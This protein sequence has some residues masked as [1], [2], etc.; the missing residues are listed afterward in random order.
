MWSS[1]DPNDRM[2]MW[3]DDL[4]PFDEPEYKFDR[5]HFA[6]YQRAIAVHTHLPALQ[7]GS[8]RPVLAD[9]SR[10]VYAF[11]R[12]DDRQTVYV[13]VNRN[14]KAGEVEIPIA[15]NAAL[16][17]WM[18][19]EQAELVPVASNDVQGRPALRAKAKGYAVEDGKVRIS[20]PA[21]GAAILAPAESAR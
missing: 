9:D 14:D 20:L 1:D 8:F 4:G 15:S 11:A 18:N 10:G 3:W 2:P 7:T 19:P 5:D 17:D 12:A 6:F 13:V 21:Y 16:I